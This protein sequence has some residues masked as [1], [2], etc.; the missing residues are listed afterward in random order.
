MSSAKVKLP[1][2]ADG[3]YYV[4]VIT[5]GSADPRDGYAPIREFMLGQTRVA[6]AMARDGLLPRGLA[7]VHPSFR[8]PYKIT[9]VTGPPILVGPFDEEPRG[10]GDCAVRYR[11][12]FI[13]DVR[14]HGPAVGYERAGKRPPDPSA[15]AGIAAG[16][17]LGDTREPFFE[18]VV[19]AIVGVA[20]LEIEKAEHFG[21]VGHA[22]HQQPDTEYQARDE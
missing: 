16:G 6:F 3:P 5:D 21:R 19:K 15:G 1:V 10:D 2:G 7:R 20:R 4:Y 17:E 8:T 9:L 22:R 11:I 18:L 12:P 14:K 13:A